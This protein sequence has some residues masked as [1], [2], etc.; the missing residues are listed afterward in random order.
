MGAAL[1]RLKSTWFPSKYSYPPQT[2]VGKYSILERL[3]RAAKPQHVAKRKSDG[4]SDKVVCSCGWESNGYWDLVEAAF[5]EWLMHLAE[6]IGLV[7]KKCVCGETYIPFNGEKAC[8]KLRR[9]KK[10]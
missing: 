10:K 4:M 2:R 3:K 5:D 8:H 7:P 9:T 1:K 6:T